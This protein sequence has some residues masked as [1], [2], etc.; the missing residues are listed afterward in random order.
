MAS[1]DYC[2]ILCVDGRADEGEIKRTYRN[3]AMQY[4]PD[5]NPGDG[6]IPL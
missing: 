5:R 3:L 2:E 6:Q 4:H 1:I